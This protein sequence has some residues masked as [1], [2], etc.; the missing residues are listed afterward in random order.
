MVSFSPIDVH[1]TLVAEGPDFKAGFTDTLPTGNVD[2]RAHG[3]F[4]ARPLAAAG[5]WPSSA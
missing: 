5:G 4:P 1:N 2:V 3:R